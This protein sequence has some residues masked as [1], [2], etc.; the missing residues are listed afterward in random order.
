MPRTPPALRL[1]RIA[2]HVAA[3]PLPT[4][5]QPPTPTLPQHITAPSA[6]T[7]EEMMADEGSWRLRLG[8][9][10]LTEL[11][12]AQGAII[13]GALRPPDLALETLPLGPAC[14]ALGERIRLGLNTG[15]GFA[16]LHGFPVEGGEDDVGALYYRLCA[17]VG[18]GITQNSEAGLVHKVTDGAGRPQ[19]GKRGVGNP[20]P[21]R[22]HTDLTDCVSLLC[23]RQAPD[24]PH[25]CIG[26]SPNV[27]N[28]I[29]EHKPEY[30]PALLAGYRWTRNGEALPG[31]GDPSPYRVPVF[32]PRAYPLSPGASP[33]ST[34]Y[35]SSWIGKGAAQENAVPP[36]PARQ[37]WGWTLPSGS[38]TDMTLSGHG[39]MAEHDAAMFEYIDSIM[40]RDRLSFAFTAGDV[41]FASNHVCTHGRDGHDVVPEEGRKRR[42]LRVRLLP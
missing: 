30:L 29:A 32:S 19:Q 4:T 22:L 2:R 16:L 21:V 37:D 33:V 26:S 36:T 8:G 7:G 5:K 6:W 35:N 14:A 12:T 11:R 24:D 39:A 3:V 34:R 28:H 15:R 20:G 27:F 13:A 31:E 23:V 41:Q 1:C 38:T 9:A 40:A 42:L 18:V 25:S 10:E 17:E